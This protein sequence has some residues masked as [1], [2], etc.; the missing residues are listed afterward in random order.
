M[1]QL[2][3][4]LVAG[5]A[6]DLGQLAGG[7]RLSRTARL[8]LQDRGRH[9]D[10]LG[11]SL[12]APAGARVQDQ[13]RLR[14]DRRRQSAR[15]ADHA[16]RTRA[17]LCQGRGQDG[18]DPHQ[19]HSRSARQQQFQGVLHRRQ[20]ARLQAGQYRPH[21]DQQPAAR[22]SPV[23][24]ADRLLLPGLQ[25]LGEVVDALH[26]NSGGDRYR[27]SGT[28]A[29]MHGAPG[30]ARRFRQGDRRALCRQG[31]PAAGAEGA[32]GLRRRQYHREPAPAAQFGLGQVSRRARQLLGPGRQELHASH[33]RLGLRGV[34]Q[35]GA[36]VPRHHDGRRDP[37]R[38]AQ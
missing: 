34:R 21:G 12:A 10:P 28:T 16:R 19:R 2:S 22:R 9:H 27:Q 13:D 7:A 5:Q 17:L 35:A 8:D 11:W 3:A 30:P 36:H 4:D 1:G 14:R 31:R 33:D 37:G 18:R 24:P 38:S 23:M 6:H 20:A 32:R 25:V 29:G 26:R 15:L